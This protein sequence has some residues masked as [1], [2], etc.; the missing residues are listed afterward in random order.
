MSGRPAHS[1]RNAAG[2]VRTVV[3]RASPADLDDGDDDGP[4]RPPVV[5]QAEATR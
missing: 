2:E 3:A 1:L 5:A 4:A